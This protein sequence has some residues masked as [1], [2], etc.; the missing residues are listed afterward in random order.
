MTQLV[1]ENKKAGILFVCQRPDAKLFKPM[2]KRDPKFCNALQTAHSYGVKIWCITLNIT[3]NEITY[4]EEI[5]FQLEKNNF[6]DI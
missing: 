6:N 3:E 1:K 4:N 2:W 5:P